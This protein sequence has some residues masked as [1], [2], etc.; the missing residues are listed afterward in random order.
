M[1]DEK[2]DRSARSPRRVAAGRENRKG[3]GPLSDEARE[4]VRAKI[5]QT[6]PWLWATGPRTPEGKTR[7]AD[8]GRRAQKGEISVPQRRALLAEVRSLLHEIWI[9]TSAVH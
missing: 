7:V 1:V 2:C 3:R 5:Q 4:R 6:K 9:T 8:N